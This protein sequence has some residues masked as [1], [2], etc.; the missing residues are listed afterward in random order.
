MREEFRRD[1]Q[2]MRRRYQ[3]FDDGMW[4]VHILP[5]NHIHDSRNLDAANR[6][7]F[8]EFDLLHGGSL[9]QLVSD[10]VGS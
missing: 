1:L 9:H 5:M 7:C 10:C 2:A 3:S 8:V 4:S 6:E